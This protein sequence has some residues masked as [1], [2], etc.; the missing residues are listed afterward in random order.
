M[1]LGCDER[2][3][4][5]PILTRT[6]VFRVTVFILLDPAETLVSLVSSLPGQQLWN[7]VNMREHLNGLK[8]LCM[9]VFFFTLLVSVS[10]WSDT[11][12]ISMSLRKC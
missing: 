9:F 10:V 5:L 1:W 4:W 7:L 8:H 6:P 12:K 11:E 2:F 3:T